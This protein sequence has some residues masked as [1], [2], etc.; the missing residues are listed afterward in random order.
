[1]KVL[2]FLG[3]ALG[4]LAPLS[5]AARAQTTGVT[6]S[7]V[8][9]FAGDVMPQ[10]PVSLYS[11]E[12]VVELETDSSGRFEFTNLA[13]GSYD[14]E[15][16]FRGAVGTI[17]GIRIEDKNVGPLTVEAILLE[18][19]YPLDWNCGRHFWSSYKKDTNPG[20]RVS[21]TLSLYPD[22]TAPSKL[23]AKVRVD[24][25]PA[26][27]RLH[28]ISAHFDENGKL[29]L[30]NVA[31]GRY[32]VLATQWGYWKVHPVTSIWVM[33]NDT[34]VIRILMNKH[35]HPLICE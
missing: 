1:M 26:D 13:P 34:T 14:V 10:M 33:R 6:L 21:G 24:L 20:S 3:L 8:V 19:W 25:V 30:T 9:R 2:L 16:S 4:Q 22:I 7:G 31:P 15:A 27:Q 28:R 23:L 5:H 29:D 32:S 11:T 17:Y 12:H 18:S 35:G